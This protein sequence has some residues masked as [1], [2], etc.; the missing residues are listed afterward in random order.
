MSVCTRQIFGCSSLL[1]IQQ[2]PVQILVRRE[3]AE[4]GRKT[5]H[6]CI[7]E[8]PVIIPTC[9]R[10]WIRAF[11]SIFY[12]EIDKKKIDSLFNPATKAEVLRSEP[13]W[14]TSS[15]EKSCSTKYNLLGGVSERQ[16]KLSVAPLTSMTAPKTL[17][18]KAKAALWL[19]S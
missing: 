4:E 15:P 12:I 8:C 3:S 7:M 16:Q 2:S 14:R 18:L 13:W 9:C 11:K 17:A 6:F 10:T 1:H 19:E 5:S